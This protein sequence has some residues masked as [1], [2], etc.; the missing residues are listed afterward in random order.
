MGSK[1]RIKKND[2]K[3]LFGLA[4]QVMNGHF[5]ELYER[6]G[7]KRGNNGNFT[8]I[9]P[10]AHT[11]GADNNP[12]L[13]VDNTT[14]VWH[15]FTCN[16]KGN[17]Q[18]YWRDYLKGGPTGISY[19]DFI[20]DFLGLSTKFDF[21]N[22][23]NDKDYDNKIQK[24]REMADIL[25]EKFKTDTGRPYILA[26]DL[27]DIQKEE[28]VL[29]KEMFDKW[30]ENLLNNEEKLSYLKRTRNIEP[31]LITKFRL[32]LDEQKRFIFPMIDE[33]GNYVNAKAYT[34]TNPK[35]KWIYPFK[36]RETRPVPMD[37]F[38]G[39]KLYFFE[40]EPDCYCAIA[41]G[42]PGVT[43]G[44]CKV[45]DVDKIFGKETAKRLFANKEIVICFDADKEGREGAQLL[46][47]HLYQYAKQIK[48][49]D[50][51]YHETRNPYGLDPNIMK[52]VEGKQ[53][54]AQ[55]DFTDFMQKNGMNEDAKRAFENLESS[56]DVFAMN[57]DRIEDETYKVTLQEARNTKYFSTE[58]KTKLELIASVSACTDNS[59]ALFY[60]TVLSA[61]CVCM[62]DRKNLVGKCKNCMLPVLPGFHTSET[63]EFKLTL[64]IREKNKDP[65]TIFVD[66]HNILGF[67]E[68]T[69]SEYQKQCRR[70]TEVSDTCKNAVFLGKNPKKMLHV[71]LTKDVNEIQMTNTNYEAGSSDIEMEGY[72]VGNKDI[73]PNR[74]YLLNA[75]QTTSWSGQYAVLFITHAE[76]V[77]SSIETFTM[78]QE[79]HD[80]LKV[81][82]QQPGESIKDTFRRRYQAFGNEAGIIGRE[83]V[84]ELMDYS[85]FSTININNQKM[86]PGI[87]RGWVE[88]LIGGDSRCGK[89]MIATYLRN[90][91]KVGE[92]IAGSSAVSR[93]GLIG[94]VISYRGKPHIAWGRIPMND[95][96]LIILD[97][98]SNVEVSALNDMTDC[99]S[100]GVADIQKNVSGKAMARTR[101]IMLSNKRAPWKPSPT[102]GETHEIKMLQ[103]LCLKDEIL[104]R[105]D[106]AYAVRQSDV[107]NEKFQ[108]SYKNSS[109]EFTDYQCQR[110]IMWA[111]S[112]RTDDYI[113]E[114]GFEEFVNQEHN[115]MTKKYHPSMQLVNSEFRAKVTRIAISISNMVYG[116]LE[117]DWNKVLVKIEYAKHAVEFLDEIY[118]S[119]NM[120]MES[121][122]SLLY[123]MEILG[124][125]RFM[126]NI[127]KYSDIYQLIQ[128]DEFSL[129][130]FSPIFFDYLDRLFHGE[131]Y[132]V[133][134]I[135]DNRKTTNLKPF[136]GLHKLVGIMCS[137][138]CLIKTGN[139]R[140]KKTKMFT[141]WLNQR[142][143][144]GDALPT[145]DILESSD[146]KPN[147]EISKVIE[148][149][150]KHSQSNKKQ[151]GY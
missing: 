9:Q 36:G 1:Y 31:S 69:D 40:G 134:S 105:F 20:I 80:M 101:K 89:S 78:D 99:R 8:C 27:V 86:L 132:I 50:L 79:T 109:S 120:G 138:N 77:F 133:D 97:E 18:S 76:P 28:T 56:S 72:F 33:E 130:D 103:A 115:R 126:E 17:F 95:G 59:K 122:S 110:H 51:D 37:N 2:L 88:V 140:Y 74:S 21:S 49:I 45:V 73:Y 107:P 67:V 91:Y 147:S 65:M 148:E 82:K 75:I 42:Y 7:W 124:D 44:P 136:E 137:R 25:N 3:L 68:V 12:S 23:E 94:G 43:L 139:G 150:D 90:K 96:G 57:I 93:T 48:I 149:I 143:E 35:Y 116:C 92:I 13:S 70:I 119:N 104:A 81:F 26:Q 114:D 5:H 22:S 100:S 34:P 111:H 53:K 129:N 87:S 125:M 123:K 62:K 84:F 38:T 145:S 30:V 15:C 83:I 117:D 63:M 141:D 46:A 14:G 151:R 10:E 32:G 142:L 41:F 60:P 127:L 11:R 29:P 108:S 6:L 19:T 131:I 66:T 112:R 121:Q 52:D 4:E 98:L 61:K 39:G 24:L 54:R 113:Y 118:A 47:Q 146:F 128:I 106:A 85:F 135:N 55:K 102:S 144:L 16:C 64:D 58:G 71:V